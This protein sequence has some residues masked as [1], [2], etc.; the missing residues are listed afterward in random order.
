M[1]NYVIVYK[2]NTMAKI[3]IALFV[4]F[5][6]TNSLTI[7]NQV[8]IVRN[9]CYERLAL[10]QKLKPQD[11]D[12]K[13]EVTTVQECQLACT[14]EDEKCRSF[15]FGIGVKGNATCELTRIVIK[16][17]PELKPI[18]TLSDI[19]YDLYI[20][21]L[22]CKL[23]IPQSPTQNTPE[24]LNA[25]HTERPNENINRPQSNYTNDYSSKPYRVQSSYLS[26]APN[27]DL[28]STRYGTGKPY[29]IDEFAYNRSP[30]RPPYFNRPYDYKHFSEKFASDYSAHSKDRFDFDPRLH[31]LDNFNS[32]RPHRI[33]EIQKPVLLDKF[34]DYSNKPYQP[35]FIPERPGRP[36]ATD[37]SYFWKPH[38]PVKIP[39][40]PLHSGNYDLIPKPHHPVEE[41][42]PPGNYG[43]KPYRPDRIPIRPEL[44]HNYN[45]IPHRPNLIPD[46]PNTGYT[47][48][49]DRPPR[50]PNKPNEYLISY[51]P[52]RPIEVPDNYGFRPYDSKRPIYSSNKPNN[53][54]LLEYPERPNKVPNRPDY[55]NSQ[56]YRPGSSNHFLSSFD[57][58]QS[59]LLGSER[60]TKIPERPNEYAINSNQAE[61]PIKIP[62]RP[63]NYGSELYDLERPIKILNRPHNYAYRPISKGPDY[64]LVSYGPERPIKVPN[65][66]NNHDLNLHDSHFP[67]NNY[68]VY[69]SDKPVESHSESEWSNRPH[70]PN[71]VMNEYESRPHRPAFI[72][73][74]PVKGDY[75]DDFKPHRPDNMYTPYNRP[76]SEIN[77]IE[78]D[79]K[80]SRSNKI[81]NKLYSSNYEFYKQRDQF[82]YFDSYEYNHRNKFWNSY[83]DRYS[84]PFR[85]I[86][87]YRY[88]ESK[89]ESSTITSNNST[90]NLSI[91]EKPMSTSNNNSKGD[92][93]QPVITQTIGPFG[94]IITSILTEIKEAC[95]RRV[96][97]GKRILRAFVRKAVPCER[98]EECQRECSD[99]RRFVCEGFNYRLDPTGRG[100]GDCELIDLPL[101]RLDIRRDVIGDADYDYYERDRNSEVPNCKGT[102]YYGSYGDSKHDYYDSNRRNDYYD[103][104]D[105][106]NYRHSQS[107][108]DGYDDYDYYGNRRG[109][110]NYK[111][112]GDYGY[113]YKPE[114][115]S[116]DDKS[117]YPPPSND[118]FKSYEP[119]LPPQH[120]KHG[121]PFLESD[122]YWHKYFEERVRD[123]N[124]W[125]F[126]NQKYDWGSYGGSYGNFGAPDSYFS[127]NY[128]NYPKYNTSIKKYF[129]DPYESKDWNR[130]G[131][132]YGYEG[133]KYSYNN[134]DSYDYWGFNKYNDNNDLLPPY[135]IKPE[136]T[137]GYLPPYQP[138]YDYMGIKHGYRNG[139]QHYHGYDEYQNYSKDQCSLRMAAGFRL[140][141]GIIKKIT[142][143]PNI[144]ECE[145]LCYK[146]RDF[147]CASYAFRYTIINNVHK[148]NCYLTDR[149]YKELDYYTDLE[150]DRD[151]D[152]YTINN[153]DT[154]LKPP[155]PLEERSECFWR[156]RSG[157]RLDHRIAK[158][159]LTVK[160]IVECQLECLRSNIF[161]CRAFSYRYGAP[162]IGGAI[163][164]CQ[165]TD[166]PYYDLNPHIHFIPEPGYEIYERGSYGYG[167]EPNHIEI[168]H[169][170]SSIPE[171][172]MDLTCYLKYETSARLLPQATK[173]STA[174][175]NEIEC[176]AECT[177]A[178]EK[179]TFQCMSFSF[180]MQ[181]VKGTSNCDLS[182]ILQ[183]DLLSNVD[184]VVDPDAW[185]FAWDLHNP[186]CVSVIVVGNTIFGGESIV[187][188]H[189][190]H[191][192]EDAIIPW[193][194]VSR[195]ADTW[196]VY[197]VNG[198]PC[199]R[200]SFCQEN[201][202]AGFWYC[203]LENK[204]EFSWDYCCN[205]EHQCGYSEG[206]PYQWCY[207]GP[208]K[209]QWR[210]CND[211]YYPYQSSITDRYDYHHSHSYLPGPPSNHVPD[212][213]AT[214]KP[215]FRPNRPPPDDHFLDPPKPGGF[216]QSRHWPIS[217]LHKELPQNNSLPDMD[218]KFDS[219]KAPKSR[220]IDT[221][222]Q[223][224]GNL[225]KT[226]KSNE[227]KLSTN[228]TNKSNSSLYVK[229]PLPSNSTDAQ[230]T[231]INPIEV[232]DI[233]TPRQNYT[234]S[235]WQNL[236]RS[237]RAYTRS[238]IT[239]TNRT[240][241]DE[242]FKKGVPKPL[243]LS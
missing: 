79:E 135:Q 180:R 56:P 29:K 238:Y 133:N 44:P 145:L 60:P 114:L 106:Y 237:S 88:K 172:K 155:K 228:G 230:E 2:T 27:S 96:L 52:E 159:S 241:V 90:G 33:D 153:K 146:E 194:G 32:Y 37:F 100:Q 138:G 204:E 192:K 98:V 35:D 95:F 122:Q 127:Y 25:Q 124:Y 11:V 151:Y 143:V 125:G 81:S 23:V 70:Q 161:I 69:E 43:S 225:I 47:N 39:D 177:R 9:D 120:R 50:L 74:K 139:H 211:H 17:T 102:R 183:R 206:F 5:G 12:K 236:G 221:N 61:R 51:I 59:V 188:E 16:E 212:Y 113:Y 8:N 83:D 26:V 89:E 170:P 73:F 82:D 112:Y 36:V 227:L 119:Y 150:P 22:G 110:K 80:P 240:T 63:D 224:I 214:S 129:F 144:Y 157:Q 64:N 216:G 233:T 178:R 66:P 210:K 105:S 57:N 101:S 234:Q 18:G 158:D 185:L 169:K 197:S 148:E 54:D 34:D 140:H 46:Q 174:V 149:N 13:L 93:Y 65:R 97:A 132:T 38:R 191:H 173:K 62:E 232:I 209:T 1:F 116:Q 10:G 131:G 229:I 189:G 203:E 213:H 222:Y 164:N 42:E 108:P 215:N 20:K 239:K 87:S 24:V 136:Y 3:L 86:I 219:P 121:R 128:Q 160:S 111:D 109:G 154:C 15:S 30:F 134:K 207:V 4:I 147:L 198:L 187:D 58:Y 117:H 123:K 167:C 199:K 243:A 107:R 103:Y 84:R 163:D 200:G 242:E 75:E 142:S 67:V 195:P 184:Y 179:G 40:S 85:P 49:D 31:R 78:Y 118:D 226:I 14:E 91:E 68:H 217:Y 156:V 165:L 141:K 201:K 218:S 193:Q 190:G 76:Y 171:N 205:P 72:P 6:L 166:W 94:D 19:E 176:K 92:N 21:K 202:V 223:A 45:S 48:N 220:N 130:Y 208:R 71:H 196:K 231:N 182:D 186:R 181:S 7:D 168:G 126:K 235:T 41:P 104:Y 137:G 28:Q 162:I 99:E 55:Y 115:P 77:A 175:A 53:Y 152:I